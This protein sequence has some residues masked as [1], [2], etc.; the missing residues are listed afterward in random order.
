MPTLLA[1]VSFPFLN[2]VYTADSFAALEPHR[3]FLPAAL[4]RSVEECLGNQQR[5]CAGG[6][7]ER[8]PDICTRHAHVSLREMTLERG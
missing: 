3:C 2:Y 5:V 8:E 4:R 1:C 6:A 7:C